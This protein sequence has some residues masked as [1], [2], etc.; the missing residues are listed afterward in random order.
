[1][2]TPLRGCFRTLLARGLKYLDR[3]FRWHHILHAWDV[4]IDRSMIPAR[5]ATVVLN[6]MGMLAAMLAFT[7]ILGIASTPSRNASRNNAFA[8]PS[9][10]NT[11]R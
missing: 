3:T 8:T 11:F 9:V 6:I 5:A 7:G 1:M 2:E 4:A 10:R